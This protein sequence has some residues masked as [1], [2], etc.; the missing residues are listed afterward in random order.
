MVEIGM[1]VAGVVIPFRRAG[2][3]ARAPADGGA[4][5]QIL[6]FTGVRYERLP[7]PTPEPCP[8]LD[9]RSRSGR[10]RRRS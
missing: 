9:G 8:A 10:R 4:L 2:H 7:E 6:L 3:R 1:R 5:G